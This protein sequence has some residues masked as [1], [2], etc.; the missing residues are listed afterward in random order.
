[1]VLGDPAANQPEGRRLIELAREHWVS[2]ERADI[3]LLEPLYLRRSAAE[4]QWER[5]GQ[6][7]TPR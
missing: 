1:V 7:G 5:A 6:P 2:G 3:W 4:E